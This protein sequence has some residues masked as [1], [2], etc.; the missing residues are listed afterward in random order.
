VHALPQLPQFALSDDVSTQPVAHLVSPSGQLQAPFSH[1]VPPAQ[2]TP[3]PPQ[4]PLS[5]FT[6]A[7][8]APQHDSPASVSQHAV[9]HAT[10][11]PKVLQH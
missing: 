10:S 1:D 8:A 6:L 7:H 2:T 4:L 11:P 5:V 9:P 3:Q